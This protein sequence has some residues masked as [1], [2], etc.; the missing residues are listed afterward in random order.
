[1]TPPTPFPVPG[2]SLTALDAWWDAHLAEFTADLTTWIAHPSVS[3]D[4]QAA[5]G[6]PYGPAV[7]ALFAH[8]T[9]QAQQL[10]FTVEDHAGHAIS[11]RLPGETTDEIG[12]V[13]HLDVVPEGDGWTFPAYEATVRDGCVIG[14]GGSDN[15]GAALVDLYLL[16]FLK[17][18]GVPLRHTLR[19]I[20]GGAEETS[21]DDIRH[22]VATSN[23]PAI[24]LVTDGPFPVNHAQK[25]GLNLDLFIPTGP[26][27]GGLV[28]GDAPN[29]VPDQAELVLAG[30]AAGDVTLPASERGSAVVE[31]AE[32][33][34][35]VAVQGAGGHAAF[36][37]SGTVNA[38]GV[39][40]AALAG[41]G[42]LTGPDQRAAE[43]LAAL[44]GD[45]YGGNLGADFAD[46]VSGPLTQNVGVVRPV[47]GGLLVSVDV[48]YPV[49][50]DPK[51]IE[52]A[53]QAAVEPVGG[54]V[55]NALDRPAYFLPEADPRVALLLETF[56]EV[57]G[58]REARPVA[59]GGGTHA[60]LLPGAITYGPGLKWVREQLEGTV[61]EA[62]WAWLTRRPE[63]I[64]EGHGN[65]HGPDEYVVLD[66]LKSAIKVYAAAIMRLD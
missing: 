59:M 38:V 45:P 64:P 50:D 19:V 43:T 8:V 3:D 36:P 46:A 20:Y 21:M 51:R 31:P 40:A 2:V 30:V 15:K 44:A 5:P 41:A 11:I 25:G 17:E 60:R 53:F 29:A 42:V 49:T 65:T 10:G 4:S 66:H 32:G 18:Q 23:P 14:R 56:R 47:D 27:L 39:L 63:G 55:V 48:R 1:M 61:G 12:L 52:R 57:T 9:A 62:T 58:L 26:T 54:R 33:G 35:R 24:S 13:S 34:S 37:E 6:A 28:A 16:R 22:V 7:A